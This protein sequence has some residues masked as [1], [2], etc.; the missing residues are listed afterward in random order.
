MSWPS[1]PGIPGYTMVKPLGI[2]GAEVYLGVHVAT[3][4]HVVLK[5]WSP[6]WATDH[7]RR[8]AVAV[9]LRHPNILTVLEVGA[10]SRGPF[11]VLEWLPVAET[12][13]EALRKREIP[14]STAA[15]IVEAVAQ[16][17]QYA[18]SQDVHLCRLRLADVLLTDANVVKIQPVFSEDESPSTSLEADIDKIGALI[19]AV[20]GDQPSAETWQALRTIGVQ[21]VVGSGEQAIGSFEVL[22]TRLS[23]IVAGS[24]QKPGGS[25]SKW[26]RCS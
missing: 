8:E 2:N 24:A 26:S 16:A 23:E 3:G 19:A 6:G 12:L 9:R 14:A 17:V 1:D 21:C 15:P 11:S 22:L 25:T 7:Q 13:S 20:I 10:I 5:V 4:T 18:R